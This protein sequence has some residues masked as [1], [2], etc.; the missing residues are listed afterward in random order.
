MN[1]EVL[2]EIPHLKLLKV[3]NGKYCLV[4]EDTEVCD[5][6]EDILL[7][8]YNIQS[9]KIE[10]D[11]DKEIHTYYEYFESNF[12]A[13]ILVNALRQIDANEIKSIYKLNN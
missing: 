1:E 2:F 6:V 10:A 5:F 9:D 13:Q 4:I 7:D 8:I 12:N 11:F 3:K